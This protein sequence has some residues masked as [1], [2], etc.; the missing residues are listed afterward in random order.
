[1]GSERTLVK[2]GQTIKLTADTEYLTRAVRE[3]AA[4]IVEGYP[5]AMP[6]F[7]GLSDEDIKQLQ[8]WLETLK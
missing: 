5:P 2:D 6:P 7:P 4:E 1:M 8:S 3:P